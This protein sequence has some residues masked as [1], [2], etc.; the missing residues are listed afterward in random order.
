[1]AIG[2]TESSGSGTGLA[3]VVQPQNFDTLASGVSNYITL[4]T[5]KKRKAEEEAK[6]LAKKREEEG[7]KILS[8]SYN[9]QHGLYVS[10][11]AKKAN[12]TVA[13][14]KEDA[15]K[16]VEAGEYDKARALISNTMAELKRTESVQ[17]EIIAPALKNAD[18]FSNV[19]QS[20]SSWEQYLEENPDLSISD[21]AVS[22]SN[23]ASKLKQKKD[24]LKLNTDAQAI[25]Q[26]LTKNME[27]VDISEAKKMYPNQ[28]DGQIRKKVKQDIALGI[29]NQYYLQEQENYDALGL[30]QDEAIQDI[31]FQNGFTEK[32]D[33]NA[34]KSPTASEL[35]NQPIYIERATTGGTP[36]Y[37]VDGKKSNVIAAKDFTSRPWSNEEKAS[38]MFTIGGVN[39]IP[40]EV[41]KKNGEYFVRG[42][43]IGVSKSMGGSGKLAGMSTS[44]G[45]TETKKPVDVKLNDEDQARIVKIYNERHNGTNYRDIE[46][47]VSRDIDKG[48]QSATKTQGVASSQTIDMFKK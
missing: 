13:K 44:M 36:I 38:G 23:Y 12:E 10:P 27:N 41:Y 31:L 32:V 11:L 18:K 1:M 2:L 48:N 46:D 7:K 24:E 35:A 22:W 26:G 8:D 17:N 25:F 3:Q 19:T 5:E 21:A 28:S 14:T 37:E 16:L 43:S 29:A 33:L 34:P 42:A 4:E 47:L 45:E 15:Q 30:S 9:V 40:T 20:F 39:I 6:A